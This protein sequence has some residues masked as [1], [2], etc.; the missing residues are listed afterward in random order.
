MRESPA[1]P[2]IKGIIAE[3]GSV[4]A[5]DPKAMDVARSMF[6]DRIRY[7]KDPYGA[8]E[9]SDALVIVTEWLVYRNPDLDRVKG[10]LKQPIVVDGRNLFDPERMSR[11]GFRYHGIGRARP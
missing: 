1:I 3:G 11:H 2:L 4:I 8:V 9:Q 7:A 5:H 6:G 10:L